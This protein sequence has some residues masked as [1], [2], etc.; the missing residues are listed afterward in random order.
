MKNH[1]IGVIKLW[2]DENNLQAR[3]EHIEALAEVL[4]F[5]KI[6]WTY[7]RRVKKPAK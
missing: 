7:R 6:H 1:F 2:L 4:A 3:P 5:S